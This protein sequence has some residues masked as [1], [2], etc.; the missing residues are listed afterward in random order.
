M[1]HSHN[2]LKDIMVNY[3]NNKKKH[4]DTYYLSILLLHFQL[5]IKEEKTP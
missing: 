3:K 4:H 1:I 5:R 2:T